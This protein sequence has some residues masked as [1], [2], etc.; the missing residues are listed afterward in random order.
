MAKQNI[1]CFSL[2][3]FSSYSNYPIIKTYK[4]TP[5]TMTIN[6][7]PFPILESE[8]LQLRKVTN[9][10]VNE[11]FELRSNPETMKYI[12]RPLAK[13]K[14]DALEHIRTTNLATTANQAI[15]WAITLKED[16][17]LI[18]MICLIRMQPEHFRSETGYILHPDQRGKGIM[19]EALKTVIDYAFDTIKFHSLVAVMDAENTASAKV[20]L[21]Q[22]F[23][24]EGQF[25]Q[26]EFYNGKFLDTDHYSLLNSKH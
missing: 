19:N 9:D 11:V 1:N 16:N 10:D 26:N 12:P 4:I 21:K 17:K 22:G 24:R 23:V 3:I 5:A 7:D 18:G 20:V 2:F 25:K 15:N 13:T 14:E 8:R 6:F